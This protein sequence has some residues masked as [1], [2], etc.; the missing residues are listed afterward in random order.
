MPDHRIAVS[1]KIGTG[2]LAYVVRDDVAGIASF[3]EAHLPRCGTKSEEGMLGLMTSIICWNNQSE[4]WYPGLWAVA[5]SRVSGQSGTMTDSL[6][7]LFA[8]PVNIY[9][10]DSKFTGEFCQRILHV[11][12]GF[13]GS[14]LIGTAVKDMLASCLDNLS[15]MAYYDENGDVH[16]SVEERM[17]SIEEI[18]RLAQKIAQKY[19]IA[20]GFSYP[21]N[22]RCEIVI[23]GFCKKSNDYKIFVLKNAP[24]H[25]ADILIEEKN[26][27]AGEYL[28]LGDKVEV[29]R[30]E[31]ERKKITCAE[32]PYWKGRTPIVALQQI[33]KDSSLASVGGYAHL[34]IATRFC[35]RTMYISDSGPLSFQLLGFDMLSDFGMLGGYS[36]S[37]SPTLGTE[38]RLID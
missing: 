37:M 14:T 32:Y 9:E 12:Y 10:G 34:C 29:V 36:V 15:E 4:D 33:I 1:S 38:S 16:R 19:L 28:I 24:E 6:Q 5:D 18:A 30:E 27:A 35:S 31:I 17:P 13:S 23:F 3:S 11:C 8:L 7:K 26:I 22:A 20:V 2:S 21:D 25:P